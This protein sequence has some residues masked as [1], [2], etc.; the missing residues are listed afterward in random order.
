MIKFLSRSPV[1]LLTIAAALLLAS[2][3]TING[4]NM[5]KRLPP[6]PYGD[7]LSARY[8]S[9]ES[10]VTTAARYYASA[11][12][13]DPDNTALLQRAM[14]SAVFASRIEQAAKYA[15]PVLDANPDDRLAVLILASNAMADGRYLD[16]ET[17]LSNVQLGPLNK[18]AGGLIQGWALQGQ[19]KTDAALAALDEVALTPGLGGLSKFHKALIL[20]QAG[21]SEAAEQAF[22]VSLQTGLLSYRTAYGLALKRWAENDEKGAISALDKRL[23]SNQ[24]EIEAGFLRTKILAGE[25]P[26]LAFAT[27]KNGAGEALYG[28]AQALASRSL[29]ELALIYLEMSLHIDPKND[30]AK[31]LLARLYALQ[32]RGEDALAM[33]A[34]IQPDTPW[35]MEAQM[36]RANALFR[37]ERRKEAIQ[38]LQK[39]LAIQPNSRVKRALATAY[40]VDKRY[41]DALELFSQLIEDE[42]E[43]ADW[44]LYFSRAVCL[45]RTERWREAVPDFRKSLELQPKQADVLNYLGYTFINAGENLDE[46]FD[47]IRQ[48]IALSPKAGYIVDS[49]GWGYY[50]LGRFDEAVSELEKAVKLEPGEPTINDHLGDAY[51][52]VG[53]RLEAGFQWQRVL[54]LEPDEETDLAQIKL[55]LEKGLPDLPASKLASGL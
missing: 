44:R 18:V 50:K 24:N 54:T 42:P 36:D 5:V 28:L 9:S 22:E 12:K 29:Q 17:I 4:R 13:K 37:L 15:K 33:F 11:L 8:A 1:I 21:R 10:D 35:Y 32:E 55:K 25:R 2:C 39:L 6:S 26:R 49:L 3:G 40:Q 38:G 47:M 20:S 23:A 52:Q 46:G 34:K 48:A 16:T 53:R 30:A 41:D 51:W 43:K 45:E 27:P 7:Y 14:L 19:G 31:D